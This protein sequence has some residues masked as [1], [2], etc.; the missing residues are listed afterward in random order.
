MA[1]AIGLRAA[2]VVHKKRIRKFMQRLSR[3]P[4]AIIPVAAFRER[5]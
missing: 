4:A 2:L 1:S 5:S 3:H